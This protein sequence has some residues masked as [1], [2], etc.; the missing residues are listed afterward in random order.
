M[1]PSAI[2]VHYPAHILNLVVSKSCSVIPITNSLSLISKIRD[3]QP[4]GLNDT[5]QCMIFVELF[6]FF[7]KSF[8]EISKWNYN[9]TRGMA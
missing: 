6:E 1:Y 2:Y 3:V 7:V 8:G 4:G 5:T 9:V